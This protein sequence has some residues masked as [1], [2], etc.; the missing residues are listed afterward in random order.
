MRS[1]IIHTENNIELRHELP[2]CYHFVKWAGGKGQ[3]LSNLDKYSP[4][5]K[6]FCIIR[7][8]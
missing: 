5:N 1:H 7:F 4:K 6:F 2:I 3:L 8:L